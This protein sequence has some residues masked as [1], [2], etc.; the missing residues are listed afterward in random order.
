[1]DTYDPLTAFSSLQP[2]RLS[3]AKWTDGGKG[4]TNNNN[5]NLQQR[6][7]GCSSVAASFIL[8]EFEHQHREKQKLPSGQ[9]MAQLPGSN[10]VLQT[11]AAPTGCRI[12]STHHRHCPD[13][14]AQDGV[15]RGGSAHP[16]SP[17]SLSL[18]LQA[19]AV[20]EGT[21]RH[22]LDHTRAQLLLTACW[23]SQVFPRPWGGARALGSPF[24][25]QGCSGGNHQLRVSHYSTSVQPA[26]SLCLL[27]TPSIAA[28]VLEEVPLSKTRDYFL[29]I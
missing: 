21:G 14:R 7:P 16:F 3:P 25:V 4:Q 1:M 20:T 24:R 13:L 28:T 5:E 23:S 8:L 11:S 15:R 29:K 6:R 22:S 18:T 17:G 9:H 2:R 27:I 26:H 19:S 12:P 10:P